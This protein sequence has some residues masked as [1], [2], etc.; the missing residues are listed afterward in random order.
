MQPGRTGQELITRDTHHKGDSC[1]QRV[2]HGLATGRDGPRV[3]RI[4]FDGGLLDAGREKLVRRVA[5]IA[6][7]PEEIARYPRLQSKPDNR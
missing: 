3:D 4:G 5:N 1:T 7:V 2:E 6:V